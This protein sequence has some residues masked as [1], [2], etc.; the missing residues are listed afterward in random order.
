MDLSKDDPN[1]GLEKILNGLKE[2]AR[3]CWHINSLSLG[4]TGK[5]LP[6]F[7]KKRRSSSFG[8]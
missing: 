4:S 8:L 3:S 6:F 2:A 5:F 1:D 7:Q